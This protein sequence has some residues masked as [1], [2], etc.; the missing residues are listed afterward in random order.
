MSENAQSPVRPEDLNDLRFL[1]GVQLTP[2]GRQVFYDVYYVNQEKNLYQ[3]EIWQMEV[4]SGTARRL[5]GGP[6]RD[7]APR[8][9][10]DGKR[11][12]FLS[13]RSEDGKKQ[14]FMLELDQPGEARQLTWMQGGV[15]GLVWS[16]DNRHLAVLSETPDDQTKAALWSRPE[17]V[18][19]RHD[20]E[21]RE[22]EE[23][24]IGGSPV[25][26]DR[27]TLR[28]DGRRSLI[29][30]DAHTQIWLIDSTAP[31]TPARQL[32]NG[33]FGVDQLT[34]SP[35]GQRLVFSSTRDQAQADF[36][37]ISDLWLIRPLAESSEPIKLTTSKGPAN[38]PAWS[39]DG[40]RLAFIGHT[41]PRD[42]SFME[43]N[44]VWTLE[45]DE[46]DAEGEQKCLT[47]GFDYHTANLL[48]SDMRAGGETPLAW[49]RDGQVYFAA[50][51]G[52]S[53]RL[54][55]VPA[56]GSR[57]P[58][59]LTDATRQVYA[60][61][62]APEAGQVAFAAADPA[63]P[64]DLFIQPLTTQSV[65]PRRLTDLNRE[66]LDGKYI[67]MPE[68]IHIPSQDGTVEIE[69]WLLKPP[70]FDPSKK[71]PLVL[72]IHGGPHTCYGHSFYH[73]FQILAGQGSVVLYTNPR[74]SIGYGYE[75]A[76]AI[77]NDWGHHDYDDVMAAVDYVIDQGYIDPAR[78]GVTGGSYGGYMTN[79]IIT[80][81]DRF[82]A[83]LTQ[84]AVTNLVSMYTLSDIGYTFIESEFEGDIWSNPR[85]WERSPL[86]H[87]N[88]A[89]TPT[90]MLHSE[91]DFRCPIEQA[92]EFFIALKKSGCETELVRTPGEDHNLSRSGSPDHRIGRLRRIANWFEQKL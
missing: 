28:A 65:S 31:E 21:A 68:T 9:S 11:L 61:S 76:A 17:S 75:F 39:P 46:H 59:P 50:T 45:L 27:L 41:N 79:W 5:T 37:C 6:R 8:L 16:G 84:R 7:S 82:K 90:L 74:G 86:A 48:N 64:G 63:C 40:K 55:E 23:K 78:M 73:E 49:N 35:D 43:I 52:A 70:G 53:L 12:A 77:Y 72:Q 38:F 26:F 83:A 92:E 89:R 51:Q 15:S 25:V 62:F 20:R 30:G 32:T 54:F 36:T 29:P 18:E 88:K 1:G 42:G 2:D 3:G 33:P 4:A 44:R 87:A 85:I 80:H 24:R 22:Q 10:S 47:T 13:D 81:T 57:A 67:A 34:F 19:A 14:V 58:Q 66:W 60:Y 56:D 91:A 69:G 71:Y